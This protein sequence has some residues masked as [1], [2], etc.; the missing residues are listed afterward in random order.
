MCHWCGYTSADAAGVFRIIHP[1]YYKT[2]RILCTG[3]VDPFFIFEAFKYGAEGVIIYGCRLG[4][5]KYSDGNLQ[6]LLIG[7]SAKT[8]LEE[9]GI[10]ENSLKLEWISSTESVKLVKDLNQFFET[11][12]NIGPF[13]NETNWNEKDKFLYLDCASKVCQDA[14]IGVLLGNISKKLKNLRDLSYSAIKQK[15][16]EKIVNKL[17]LK[18]VEIEEKNL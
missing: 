3:R 15:I 10:N 6:V 14:K 4:E 9:S 12:K 16:E 2:I 11:I 13:G 7:E 8:I 1:P 18:W 17:K 5:C